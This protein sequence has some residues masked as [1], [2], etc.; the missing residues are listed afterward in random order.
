MKK[1]NR[2]EFV[3]GMSGL[4]MGAGLVQVGCK[5]SKESSESTESKPKSFP[6]RKLGKTGEE[7]SILT[8]GG[9]HLGDRPVPDVTAIEIVRRAI[10]EGINFL[11]NANYYFAGRSETLMGRA[12][13]DGYREK[14]LLMT[15]FNDRTLDGIKK[16]LEESLQRFGLDS[17]DLM[18]FHSVGDRDGDVDLI[19]NNKL[20]EWAEEMR[21]QGVFKYIGF[22]GHADPAALRDMI[23]RGFPWDT[24]Q[25]VLS[26][27]DHHRRLS[28]EEHVLPLAVEKNIGVIAMKTN[29]FGRLS[30][31]GY[32]TAPEG[33]RYALSLP[34]ST[35]C[36]GMDSLEIL[37]ENMKVFHHYTPMTEQ[38]KT[39]LLARCKGKSNELD[40]HRQAP[41]KEGA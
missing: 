26:P 33:L 30:K 1:T 36:S 34:V 12:L 13:Q 23:E 14:V 11:D 4:A 41:E 35:V 17:F 3:K 7:V 15:K 32:G 40:T 21:S 29:S 24:V 38:E 31:S 8:L 19:Y 6:K 10:D 37:E 39:D 2:R 20:P 27:A 16:Q 22:T 18:Q 9:Y 25:M 28:F 5:D